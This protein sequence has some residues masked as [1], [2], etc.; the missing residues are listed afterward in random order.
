M[1]DCIA[2]LSFAKEQAP[3]IARGTPRILSDS[4][5][6][7]LRIVSPDVLSMLRVLR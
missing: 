1:V 3:S 6:G 7:E 4:K 2:E 5:D